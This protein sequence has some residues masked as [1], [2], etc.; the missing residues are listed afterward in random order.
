MEMT[1][2]KDKRGVG[3][4]T[5]RV[6]RDEEEDD[7]EAATTASVSTDEEGEEED[8]L[9]G[10]DG[11]DLVQ[12]GEGGGDSP[13]AKRKRKKVGDPVRHT[14]YNLPARR[15]KFVPVTLSFENLFYSVKT[16]EGKN[17]FHKKQRKTLLKDLHGQMWPGELTAIMGPSGTTL[18]PPQLL[19][20]SFA[21]FSF[22]L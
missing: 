5:P 17:P 15:T 16:R 7:L 21:F 22:V 20:P 14:M 3:F 10:E 4:A 12:E 2:L 18:L 13:P 9:E 6:E 19:P 11:G 8:E 1:T